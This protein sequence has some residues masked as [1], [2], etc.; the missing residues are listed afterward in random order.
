LSRACDLENV[1]GIQRTRRG[2]RWAIEAK[3]DKRMNDGAPPRLDGWKTIAAH[4]GRDERTVKRWEATRGLPIRRLPGEHRSSVFAYADELAAWRDGPGT[5]PDATPAQPAPL[6]LRAI[7]LGSA[8]IAV[9]LILINPRWTE[10][11]SGRVQ[12]AG[13]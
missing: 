2:E 7:A 3:G 13:E 8:A 12:A 5:V 6:S 9:A 10:L 11:V 4:I 1:G